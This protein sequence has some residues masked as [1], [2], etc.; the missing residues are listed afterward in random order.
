M[1][2][3]L[4]LSIH[5]SIHLMTRVATTISDQTHSNIFYQLLISGINM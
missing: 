3:Q 1:K 2:I 5:S 4:S